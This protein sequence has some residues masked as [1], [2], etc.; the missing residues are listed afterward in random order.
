[1]KKVL[2]S[3]LLVA[4]LAAAAAFVYRD[5]I[6]ML[7]AFNKLKPAAPFRNASAPAS[8]DYSQLASWAALPEREDSADALPAIGVLDEQANAAVDVFFVHPTTYFGT[9]NW[10]QRID[11]ARV[12]QLTD[13]FVMRGQASA[14]NGCCRIYAPRYRQAT[15]Y[16]FVDKSGSG[17]SALQ[18][19]YND[20]ER[21]FDYFLQNYSRD[22]PFVLASHS[23]GSV[24]LRRLLERRITGSHLRNRLVA[25]YPIGFNLDAEELAQAVPDVPVCE[26]AE[27]TG[28]MVSWNAVGPEVKQYADTSKN[29]CVNPLTWKTDGA[30]AEA[31]LNLGGVSYPGNFAGSLADLKELPQAFIDAKPIVEPGVADA[32]CVNGMLLVRQINSAHYASRPMGRDNYHIYDYHLFAMN[33][34]KNVELRVTQYLANPP[35]RVITRPTFTQ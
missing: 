21:A 13:L 29:I 22:R 7:V 31:A 23:Q 1:M 5:E 4:L 20:V 14:F 30:P 32:Q 9:D 33:L 15:I 27:Q 8:P 17:T 18:L 19:A 24:H 3:V 12:N 11:D 10:N 25:A 35:K 26:S 28:C 2:V 34:R 6:G 16:S